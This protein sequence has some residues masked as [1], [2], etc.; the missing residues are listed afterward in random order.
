MN[1]LNSEPDWIKQIRLKGQKDAL[2][3]DGN[4]IV[5]LYINLYRKKI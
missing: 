3:L 5:L 2:I 4:N 1:S